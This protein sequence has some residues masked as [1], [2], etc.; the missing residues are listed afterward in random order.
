[1]CSS[2]FSWVGGGGRG[3]L[4]LWCR[5]LYGF[6]KKSTSK[7]THVLLHKSMVTEDKWYRIPLCKIHIWFQWN[8][9]GN[10]KLSFMKLKNDLPS[11]HHTHHAYPASDWRKKR[12]NKPY[13]TSK[14]RLFSTIEVFLSWEK[15]FFSILFHLHHFHLMCFTHSPNG[16][17]CHSNN[18]F[19]PQKRSF[20]SWLWRKHMYLSRHW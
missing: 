1:M 5:H 10:S 2:Y 20:I 7:A 12:R 6:N 9:L 19:S 16:A 14:S 11:N 3:G 18:F 13:Y 17:H 15:S 4:E 8:S